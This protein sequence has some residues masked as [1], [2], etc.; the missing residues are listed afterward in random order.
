MSKL[1]ETER[2]Y[3]VRPPS[4]N[5]ANHSPLFLFCVSGQF[6]ERGRARLL[7]SS[8]VMPACSVVAAVLACKQERCWGA[9]PSVVVL[10]SQTAAVMQT[11]SDGS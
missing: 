8:D 1:A 6:I 10:T 11:C 2:S 9:M 7:G 4:M 5:L 3:Q